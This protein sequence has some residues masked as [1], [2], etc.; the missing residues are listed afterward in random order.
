MP[1]VTDKFNNVITMRTIV[2]PNDPS[3][4]FY[5]CLGEVRAIYKNSL[6]LLF[7]KTPNQFML[8]EKNNYFA[9]KAH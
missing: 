7:T 8:R 1:T 2:K 9:C 4:P 6:F 3:C 5:N